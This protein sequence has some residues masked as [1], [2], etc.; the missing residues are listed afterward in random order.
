MPPID[1]SQADI[2]RD[3][4]LREAA[5]SLGLKLSAR[6]P[7]PAPEPVVPAQVVQFPLFPSDTRPVSNDMARSALFSCIQGKDRRFVK[8]ALLATV[9]GREIRFTGE[10]L[11]QDDHDLLMQ[12]VFMAQY[13]PLGSWVMAPAY[14]I[15]QALGRQCGGKQYRELRTDIAR[16]AASM[17]IIRDTATA[18]EKFGHH[19]IAQAEQDEKSRH[20]IYR[21][22]PD[23]CSLYGEMSHTLIDWEQRMALKGKDLARWLQLYIRSHAKPY[24]VKVATLRDLSGSRAKALKNFRAKLRV[25]L[26]DLVTIGELSRWEIQPRDLLFVD[27]GPAISGSQRRHLGRKQHG[28]RAADFRLRRPKTRTQSSRAART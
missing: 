18:R 4:G 14:S 9:E 3:P 12:M 26:D 5:I 11:N 20:W 2:I 6:A 27:R 7:D 24:P 25:A 28:L 15:L 23:L 21:L 8:D 16:L 17:V 13:K 22:D 1:L 19:L 10:Q